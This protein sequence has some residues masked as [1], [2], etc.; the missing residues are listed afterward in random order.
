MRCFLQNS[1][2]SK[3]ALKGESLSIEKDLT[4]ICTNCCKQVKTQLNNLNKSFVEIRNIKW[5]CRKKPF[6]QEYLA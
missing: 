1:K 2:F 5:Y 6:D 4:E 3:Q